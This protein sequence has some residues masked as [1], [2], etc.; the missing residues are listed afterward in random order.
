MFAWKAETFLNEAKTLAPHLASFIERFPNKDYKNYL[1]REFPQLPKIS[2]DYAIMER[3]SSVLAI[4]A[5]FD[6]DDVGSWVSLPGHLGRN[7]AGNTIRGDVI[8]HDARNNI[9]I[10]SGR[11]IALCGV[12]DLVV[13]ETPDAVL[14]CHADAAQDVKK[15]HPQMSR[16]LL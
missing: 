12:H 9:A 14:V 5:T 1:L 11:T 4:R 15:L 16:R 10:S 3:A 7:A 2:V 8:A 6:W 13:V